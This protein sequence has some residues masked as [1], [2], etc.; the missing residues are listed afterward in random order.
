MKNKAIKILKIL[1]SHNHQAVF[2][3][4]YVRDMI[5]GF[6]SHDIDIATDASPDLI[7]S[8]FD[9]TIPIG[10]S[11]GVVRVLMDGTE[12]EVATFRN[13]GQ[14]KD[15]RRPDSVSFSSMKEDAKRRDFTIN[16]L[17]YDP[18]DD[19]IYD[20]VNGLKDIKKKII[21]FIG[22]PEKRI[23]ED[24]LRILRALRFS[25]K[26][27][28]EIEK[29][30]KKS[31][32]NHNSKILDISKERIQEEFLKM[33]N[34]GQPRKMLNLL[35]KFKILEIIF[36]E[37]S[38]LKDIPQDPRWHPE[39]T[40]FE[41]TVRVMEK[42]IGESMELQIAGMFHDIG[43]LTT[44]IIH[45]D[46]HISSP[47]HAKEGADISRRIFENLKFSNKFINYVCKLIYEHMKMITVL[48]M[49]KSTQKKFFAQENYNDLRKLHIAD[50]LSSHL[51]ISDLKKIDN[52]K[53]IYE[54]EN[55]KPIPF[56][57]G[58]DLIDIGFI[59]GKIIGNIKKEI[60]NLQLEGLL[61][62]KKS[63]IKYAI[64]KLHKK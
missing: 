7:E 60:Y 17:F 43:K 6:E 59:P 44:T 36:P 56:I 39:G 28:F 45:T 46:G 37:I 4:G 33:I 49:K 34:I 52:L 58:K 5:M 50:K 15:G 27:G 48:D 42:L 61:T 9:K 35:S 25:I 26:F 63:A 54:K 10:K 30:T 21:R 47:Q 13:D 3:G 57:N 64:N 51:D 18:I 1:K 31:I 19:K 53:Q 38:K 24:K 40:V 32:L 62:D 14:Y 2:A 23:Q 20:Y 12:F 8:Y 16:G 41:H 55:L 22:N 29:N 11:F